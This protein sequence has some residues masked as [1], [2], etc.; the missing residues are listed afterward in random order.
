MIRIL[1]PMGTRLRR[2][3]PGATLFAM[4]ASLV[5]T[6]P[7]LAVH[8]TGRFQLDGDASSST[9]GTPP[10]TDDWDMVCHQ[11]AQPAN[12]ITSSNTTGSR[13]GV[14]TSEP[15]LSASIFTGG[16]SKD[17]QNINNWAWKDA[18]GLPD[19]DNLL[20]AFAVRYSLTPA[21]TCPSSELTCEVIYFGSDR[22]DNSGDA[23]QGF[24]FLQQKVGLGSNSVGGGSGFTGLHQ[25]GD[26]LVISDF[27]IGGTT[28][29]ITVYKWDP[30]CTATN[31]PDASCGDA[32]LRTLETSANAKCSPALTADAFCGIVN[33][34]TITMPWSF[35]DK[36][37][38]PSNGAL[39]GEFYEAGINLSA[40]NLGGECFS[41]MAA[42][43]RSSTSTTATLK[44]FVLGSFGS[45][46]SKIVTTAKDGSGNP[47]PGDGLSIGTGSV[48]VTDSANLSVD[49]AATWSGTVSFSL[50]GPN[51]G[52]C[53]S[54]GTGVGSPQSVNQGTAMP[55]LSDA[56][57][58][59]SAGSYCWRAD[60][61]SATTGVPNASDSGSNANEC[62]TVN[63]VTPTLGTTAGTSPVLLGQ[64]VTD[65]AT[66][67]GTA[68]QPG[69]P[70]I[71]GPLGAA[72]GGSITFTLFGPNSCSTVA[73]GTGTNPQTVPVSGDDTYGPVSFTPNAVGTYHWV[74]SYS[75]NL[76]NTNS[77]SHNATCNDTGED[78]V[79][80]QLPTT[81]VTTPVDGSGVTFTSVPFGSSVY[82][83][84]VVTGDAAGGTPT[85]TVS[86]FICDPSQ[87][88]GSAGSEVCASGNG[89]AL[90]GN[91]VTATPV[92][93]SSPPQS[94]ATSSPAVVANKT[95][96]W[97]FRATYTPDTSGY[98]G[99]SDATHNECFT[100]NDTSSIN[101]QQTWLPNDSATLTSANG[102]PLSGSLSFTLHAGLG[103]TGT[104][105]R[106]AESFTLDGSLS[107]PVTKNTTNNTVKVEVTND[108]SWEVVFN[109]DN[110]NVSGSSK[111]ENSS[112]T[113]TNNP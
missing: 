97:C 62:F 101:S 44:D 110:P 90:A 58:V 85:G 34:G 78:V 25:T 53:A 41:S 88:T 67:S 86:F 104:V 61:T 45:C 89:T 103:C 50:C 76:P 5:V 6:L 32:N 46:T 74:A 99:S 49:G 4:L 70:I 54:G 57:T 80:R 13:S 16:G 83:H 113:I 106:S 9:P 17:P 28:S 19:K 112:L 20:H 105:L 81:T 56:A 12:C 24:W 1:G 33:S 63:P 111:C 40:I 64:P 84:A 37:G 68:N 55:I 36:S 22:V 8:D 93:L 72:A 82:D 11:Y 52:T 75:G 3:L 48:S 31:K 79:V 18:G 10:A 107:S 109:S 35:T 27:S 100:V 23:Q 92:L 71:N 69:S 38:T 65:T 42:E 73:T 77:T 51:A 43:T 14:W 60:F 59:T 30:A 94:E 15:N 91:P 95:G 47:I 21:A 7:A 2:A 96:V 108:V 26:I 29:T 98:L 39:S 66:L 87:V 102:A